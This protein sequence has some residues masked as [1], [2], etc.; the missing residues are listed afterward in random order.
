MEKT[1]QRGLQLV[2]P[3]VLG[4]VGPAEIPTD[5]TWL[6]RAKTAYFKKRDADAA[7]NDELILALLN[8]LYD[9]FGNTVFV[10]RSL[11]Q[12][13]SVVL[14]PQGVRFGIHEHVDGAARVLRL[15]VYVA[16][17][18]CERDNEREFETL[19]ELGE[20][21]CEPTGTCAHCNKPLRAAG[22]GG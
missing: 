18:F 5:G 7:R 16:C 1:A 2:E 4:S 10:E 8:M 14:M 22:A 12:E 15:S 17:L 21:L 20:I 13:P 19:E 6:T 3:R 9:L 11:V